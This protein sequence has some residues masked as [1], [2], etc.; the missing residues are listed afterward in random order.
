MRHTR[1]HMDVFHAGETPLHIAAGN[2]SSEVVKLLIQRK[3]N[4]LAVNQF[5]ETALHFCARYS[6]V[7]VVVLLL[8]AWLFVATA[9]HSEIRCA[10][11]PFCLTPRGVRS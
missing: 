2:G 8:F 4:V 7:P 1:T 10:R 5:G 6:L 3:A 9:R 11:T